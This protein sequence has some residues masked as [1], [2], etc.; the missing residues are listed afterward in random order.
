M[1]LPSGDHLG[2]QS[3]S[4]PG[5][6]ANRCVT[7]SNEYIPRSACRSKTGKWLKTS[8]CPSGDQLGSISFHG[9]STTARGEP[10]LAGTTKS[11]NGFPGEAS[12]NAIRVESGDHRGAVG[13]IAGPV[14][15]RQ[16][17]PCA[18]Q[19]QSRWS[20]KLT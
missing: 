17:P 2:I 10:P 1:K 7:R 13:C 12:K 6:L 19:R 18:L 8:V 4:D 15:W 20:G 5:T 14:N 9:S 16:W 3:P 11:L